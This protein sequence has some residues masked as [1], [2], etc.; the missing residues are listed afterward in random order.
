MARRGEEIRNRSI[1]P[2]KRP[3]PRGG[4]RD[5]NRRENAERLTDAALDRFL[6]QG[7][8]AV[9]IEELAGAAAMAKGSFYRYARDKAHLVEQI[10]APVVDEVA[11]ALDRCE[12]GLRQ[13]RRDTL[14]ALYTQ[15]ALDL[16]LVVERH[17]RRV[18]LYLQEVRASPGPARRAIHALADELTR[19]AIRLTEI[20]RD[21]GLIRAVDP[22]IAA[23]AVVG[24]IDAILFAHLRARPA[25]SSTTP[26]VI[27][28][29]V[30]IVLRGIVE[31]RAD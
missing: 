22:E 27:S 29:L 6:A 8:E 18:L 12:Q 25:P 10:M 15:L 3:G 19:R 17:A 26:A 5:R 14:A 11:T 21:H 31:T 7:T 28:E 23:L 30:A 1:L 4:K 24:A 16:A 9:T 2:R 13:A 20:A